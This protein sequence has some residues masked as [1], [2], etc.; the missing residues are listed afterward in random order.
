MRIR[1]PIHW[2]FTAWRISTAYRG[3][4][5][6]ARFVHKDKTSPPLLCIRKYAREA[7]AN[8]LRNGFIVSILVMVFWLLA[9]PI[10]IVFQDSTDVIWVVLHPKV[11][12][13]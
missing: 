7:I 5:H 11:F 10:Q 2:R 4:E 12:L 3:F 9:R 13:D 8:P 6:E 1:D